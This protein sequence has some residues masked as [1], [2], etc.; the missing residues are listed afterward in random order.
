M[1]DLGR[2]SFQLN[3]LFANASKFITI[4]NFIG[5]IHSCNIKKAIVFYYNGFFLVII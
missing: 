3:R 2:Y 5:I 4:I 1:I